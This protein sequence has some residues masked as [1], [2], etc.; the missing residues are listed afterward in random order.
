MEASCDGCS[1]KATLDVTV[2]VPDLVELTTSSAS[3]PRYTLVGE[4]PTHS[5]N[6]YFSIE[7]KDELRR[8]IDQMSIL[9]WSNPG[10]ND[11]SIAWGGRFDIGAGWSGSHAGHREGE[12]VDISFLRP[13]FIG[14]ALRQKTF[15]DIKKGKLRESPQV[16]WHQFD[17]SDTGSKAHFHVYLLGQKA[18]SIT[19]Y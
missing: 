19:Q 5:K 15:D 10:I 7:G 4:T 9:E 6:H 18:S 14:P 2:R 16:L 13:A 11:A 17:N 8:L 12:E 1:N 3:P